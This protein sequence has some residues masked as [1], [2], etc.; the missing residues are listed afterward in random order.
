MTNNS[1]C[2]A[3]HYYNYRDEILHLIEKYEG[4]YQMNATYDGEVY[5]IQFDDPL[6]SDNFRKEIRLLIPGVYGY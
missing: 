2:L 1:F 6:Q 5:R 3:K 4:M